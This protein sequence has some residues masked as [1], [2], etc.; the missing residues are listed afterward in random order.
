MDINGD[1]QILPIGSARGAMDCQGRVCVVTDS[2][3]IPK[4]GVEFPFRVK[5]T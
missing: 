4:L 5:S 3:S 2:P 1:A